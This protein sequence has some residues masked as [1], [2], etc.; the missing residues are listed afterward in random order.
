M[1][2]KGHIPKCARW[3]K[4]KHLSE[5]HKRRIGEANRGEWIFKQCLFCKN[6]FH[7]PIHRETEAKYCSP[8]CYH[9]GIIGKY[10]G[11]NSSSW[12]GKAIFEGYIYIKK[13]AHPFSNKQGYIPRS[14]LVME[15]K[16]GRFLKP[17]ERVH[18]INGIKDDDRPENLRL[19]T[20]ESEHQKFHHPKG[21]KCS[22]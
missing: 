20:N 15:K 10:K 16:I 22:L 7:I 21:I 9:K 3:N 13:P 1:F 6:I 5:K 8:N 11:S 12:K 17:E 18:H 19:F 14:H 4:G 2:K